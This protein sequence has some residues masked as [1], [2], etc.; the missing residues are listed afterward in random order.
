VHVITLSE[1]NKHSGFIKRRD[2]IQTNFHQ[3]NKPSPAPSH[4]TSYTF[5]ITLTLFLQSTSVNLSQSS[6]SSTTST[7]PRS[8]AI[9]NAV[10]S[11]YHITTHVINYYQ[12]FRTFHMTVTTCQYHSKE[13]DSKYMVH[14]IHPKESR[15]ITPNDHT[16]ESHT[17]EGHRDNKILLTTNVSYLVL[18]IDFP[19]LLAL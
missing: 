9:C 17:E 11:A 2:N 18:S 4:Q 14:W 8:M 10:L 1:T 19:E 7:R 16:I 6:S 5:N 12:V 15:C 3:R 13:S